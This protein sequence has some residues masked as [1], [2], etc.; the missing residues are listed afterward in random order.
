MKQSV[1]IRLWP[2][3]MRPMWNLVSRWTGSNGMNWEI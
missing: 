3:C 1:M 2:A